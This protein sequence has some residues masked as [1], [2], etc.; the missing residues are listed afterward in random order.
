MVS[1]AAIVAIGLRQLHQG[2]IDRARTTGEVTP[3]SALAA[4]A[5]FVGLTVVNPMTLVYFV[6]LSGAATA[7]DSSW[8]TPVVFVAAVGLTSFAWQLA[9]AMVGSF[10]G[11]VV[12]DH[13]TRIIDIAAAL[14]VVALGAGVLVTGTGWPTTG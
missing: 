3:V 14:L 7:P 6:A 13:T 5:R 8:V 9:L 10:F 2:L 1:G 12:T 4:Y 11:G